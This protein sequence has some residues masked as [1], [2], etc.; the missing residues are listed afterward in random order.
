MT[1]AISTA[2][3]GTRALSVRGS[4]PASF[5]DGRSVRLV[6]EYLG[7]H[8]PS[9]PITETTVGRMAALIRQSA[10]DSAVL[11]VTREIHQQAAGEP[12]PSNEV[13]RAWWW[14]KNHV[15][16]R[17]HDRQICEMLGEC[18]GPGNYQLLIDPA[19]L[20]RAPIHIQGYGWL[21]SREGDCAVFT[22]LVL[23]ILCALGYRRL[24]IVTVEADRRRPNEY[25]HVYGAAYLDDA[26]LW[27][28]LDA[29][30]MDAPGEEVPAYDI[31]RKTS[32]DLSG[33]MVADERAGWATPAAS[34]GRREPTAGL[35]EY[36]AAV[37]GM[38]QPTIAAP[39]PPEPSQA[40]KDAALAKAQ[41]DFN[42]RSA[43]CRT[44]QHKETLLLVGATGL[45]LYA[46]PGWSKLLVLPAAG[47]L[48]FAAGFGVLPIFRSPDCDYGM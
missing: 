19:A 8:T 1:P 17:H 41:A 46:L 4:A 43:R 22:M 45:A 5:P 48:A 14:V 15:H 13:A 10:S 25:T 36:V 35:A 16:F 44:F 40:Q 27:C 7:F 21:K 34:P 28:P 23:A 18:E 11:S 9:G 26:G 2:E 39:P 6:R 32:W 42:A 33:A 24:R 47:F 29:S 31:A 37:R 12:T 20:L 38:A 30:H 3:H